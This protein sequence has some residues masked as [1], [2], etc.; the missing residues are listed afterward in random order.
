MRSM[1]FLMDFSIS[2]PEGF[3]GVLTF[4]TV[5]LDIRSSFQDEAV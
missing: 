4:D 5:L 3:L 2:F 1:A